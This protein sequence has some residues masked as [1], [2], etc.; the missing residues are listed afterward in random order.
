MY[1]KPLR[2]KSQKANSIQK[3]I[4]EKYGTFLKL[5]VFIFA[6]FFL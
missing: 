1:V 6:K 4:M 2:K 5:I 3:L